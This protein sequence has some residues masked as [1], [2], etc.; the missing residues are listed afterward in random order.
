MSRRNALAALALVFGL[1]ATLP[2]VAQTPAP[3]PNE[4]GKQAPSKAPD[5]KKE[6]PKKEEPKKEEVKRDEK[7]LDY[8][9]FVKDLKKIDGSF[10][11]YQKGK[12]LYLE[13]PESKLGQ[14]FLIQ[15]AFDTGLDNFFLH[16]GMPVGDQ[17]VDA[18][19]FD[20][21][22]ETV[23]L[24]R[25]RI[26]TRWEPENPFKLGAD[27]AF[28]EA[29]LGSFR[30]EQ[31]D[32]EKKLLL[33]NVTTLFNGDVFRLSEMITS[34]L[35]GPYQLDSAKSGPESVK[36]FPENSVVTMKMHYFS[37]RGS[38][39]NPLAVALGLAGE[40]T[41]EDSRSA[42]VK[43]VYTVWWRKDTGYVPRLADP[44]VGFFTTDF[45]SL[46][47][48]LSDDQTSKYI[49]RFDVRKKDPR[50]DVSEAV[51]P[52]VWTI[53]PSVPVQY[54]SAI[55]N[56]VLRW[57]KAFEAL[58]YKNAVQ[59]KEVGKD[60]KDYDH[61]DGR[62]NV[63]RMMS[64]P[65]APFAAISLLR[66]DPFT[67]E[68]LNASI[69]I[70]ANTIQ[71]LLNEHDR[72]LPN[73]GT[74]MV[75]RAY[76]VLLRNDSR[77]DTDD[78]Y[79]FTTPVEE[80]REA[81][82]ARMSKFGWAQSSCTYASEL[83]GQASLAWNELQAVA[84][85]NVNREEY[86]K[87]F[88]SDCVAHEMG[89]C[90]GLRHNFA[91]S[92]NL[93]TAQLSDD[94][95]TSTQGN[96]ASVMDYTPPNVQAILKGKGNFYQTTIGEYDKWAIRY[97]YESFGGKTP[98]SDLYRLSRIAA[99]SGK[100]GHAFMT[101]E[102]ADSFNPY[103]VRFDMS[104]DPINFSAKQLVALRKARDWAVT[105]LPRPGESYANR[106][107]VVLA[108]I[109]TAFREGRIAARFLGGVVAT[110]NF[111][112]D[113]GENPTLRPVTAAEQRQALSL[114]T[115]HFLAA[116]SFALPSSL[117]NSMSIDE[118]SGLSWIAPLREYVGSQQSAI[119]SLAL[120]ARTTNQIA[121]NAYK[122][123]KDPYTL[124]EH[125]GAIVGSVFTEVGQN[126]SISPLRRDLQRFVANALVIQ[127]SA[128]EGGVSSDVRL[129][130]TDTLR[131]LNQRLVT[132][133][134]KS[135]RLDDMTKL[136]LRETQGLISRYLN[137]TVT[138]AR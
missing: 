20:R 61:A 82:R 87:M 132:Q 119:L 69:T 79:L 93:T 99:E 129:I 114:I 95:L 112:G 24:V 137:R 89:H 30:I 16:A 106:T 14:L 107:K 37:P 73:N 1:S 60:D 26:S 97:G 46:D 104:K 18:F 86:V 45:W 94:S 65:T 39:P 51:K 4:P 68:I 122:G 75:D 76:K 10:T 44:R 19:R 126:V 9:K 78:H 96:S 118:G 15:A 128:P 120:S 22:E 59:V 91:G 12:N 33:V 32:P 23:W 121:E 27:R 100:P 6:E 124:G 77:P 55:R 38:E 103:A 136:H 81:V 134:A 85:P 63:I 17:A 67:G 92:T 48:F 31:Q 49:N 2:V 58:G 43:V 36:G 138:G 80:A 109:R 115:K 105:N 98:I 28:Q 113:V 13:L 40:S 62:Q 108:T 47:K 72:Y 25:P 57:N 42:P 29:I 5:T 116:D 21:N 117:L 56:G 66:T 35:G 110:R 130:A 125:Y 53:D 127:A 135:K 3:K 41:L 133:S 52:I 123:G 50:Q 74:A 64:G 131:R 102:D 111:K 90:L 101:D 54:R 11:L 8:E 88:L 7:S 70:D 34:G 84:G 71:A 83:A